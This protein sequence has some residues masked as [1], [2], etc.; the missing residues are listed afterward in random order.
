MEQQLPYISIAAFQP[1][2]SLK[3]VHVHSKEKHGLYYNN[4]QKCIESYTEMKL[5]NDKV[6]HFYQTILGVNI[7]DKDIKKE[8]VK[9]L[10]NKFAKQ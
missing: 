3:R 4:L 1:K 8:H 6:Q 5:T 7:T 9:Y 2:C 10:H